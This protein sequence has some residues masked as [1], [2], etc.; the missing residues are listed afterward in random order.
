MTGGGIH[1]PRKYS[2]DFRAL[3]I[4]I[5]QEAVVGVTGEDASFVK[6]VYLIGVGRGGAYV[7]Y[8]GNGVDLLVVIRSEEH[9]SEL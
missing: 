3:D 8:C 1:H 9:T 2:R 5:G 7:G 6:G 4:G